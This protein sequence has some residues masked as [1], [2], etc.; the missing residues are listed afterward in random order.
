MYEWGTPKDPDFDALQPVI[1]RSLNDISLIMNSRTNPPH[2]LFIN[3]S[4]T[5]KM[6]KAKNKGYTARGETT[7]K[8]SYDNKE[9]KIAN[10]TLVLFGPGDGTGDEEHGYTSEDFRTCIIPEIMHE[11]STDNL[12]SKYVPRKKKCESEIMIPVVSIRYNHIRQNFVSLREI[13][14]KSTCN[15]KSSSRKLSLTEIGTLGV[16]KFIYGRMNDEFKNGCIHKE[17]I[18]IFATTGYKLNGDRFGDPH[19]IVHPEHYGDSMQIV[20][21]MPIE[22][23]NKNYNILREAF[24]WASL[25]RI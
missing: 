10:A 22:K 1:K 7:L 12:P 20:A 11:D 17:P 8:F 4:N 25:P 21:F 2:Q 3:F 9:R 6:K 16:D 14:V 5:H 19:V 13:G 24:N 18:D 23:E 15:D